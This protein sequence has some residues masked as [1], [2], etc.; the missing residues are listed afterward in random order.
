MFM[1]PR[2]CTSQLQGSLPCE[3]WKGLQVQL[4]FKRCVGETS[5]TWVVF[6]GSTVA[7]SAHMHYLGGRVLR[8]GRAAPERGP[9]TNQASA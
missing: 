2:V 1:Q 5:V 3:G 7:C 6:L 9:Q 8:T 4:V